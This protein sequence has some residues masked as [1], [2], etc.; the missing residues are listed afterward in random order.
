MTSYKKSHSE[1]VEEK[2]RRRKSPRQ[3]E[4]KAMK[5]SGGETVLPSPA[6]GDPVALLSNPRMA[7]PANAP[8]RAQAVTELQRQ[9]G[10]TYV[11]RLLAQRSGA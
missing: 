10:N 7:H 9:R 6:A 1:Q 11:Q 5:A 8:L 3:E 2:G 4:G